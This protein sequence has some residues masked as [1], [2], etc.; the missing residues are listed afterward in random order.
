MRL[1][2]AALDQGAPNAPT[3]ESI[4]AAHA[5]TCNLCSDV[6]CPSCLSFH[7]ADH[8]KPAAA[9]RELDRER[10]MHKPFF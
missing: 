6:F 4:C 7:Q 9:D 3:A 10:K 8:P 1:V 2:P 5:E